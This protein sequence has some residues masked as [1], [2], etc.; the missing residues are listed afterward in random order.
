MIVCM[1]LRVM[2]IFIAV[3]T[4]KAGKERSIASFKG[5]AM[6]HENIMHTILYEHEHTW[7]S[8]ELFDGIQCLIHL[9]LTSHI[10]PYK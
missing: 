2:K 5:M 9:I 10:C 1:S 3:I 7:F 6:G 4:V 8:I